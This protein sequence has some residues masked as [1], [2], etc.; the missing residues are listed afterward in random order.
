[1]GSRLHCYLNLEDKGNVALINQKLA[2]IKSF[3]SVCAR[4][5]GPERHSHSQTMSKITQTNM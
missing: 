5:A 4:A 1:M 2:D 3:L